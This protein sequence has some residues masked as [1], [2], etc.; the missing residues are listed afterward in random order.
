VTSRLAAPL[1]VGGGCA[2]LILLAWS[3]TNTPYDTWGALVIV[4]PLLLVGGFGLDR[5]FRGQ[6]LRVI[7]P[8]MIAGL[9]VKLVGAAVRYWVSFE[10]Y[11]GVTDAQGYHVYGDGK[12][13]S[14]WQGGVRLVD[15]IPSGT[16]TGFLEDVTAIIY[17]FTGTSR[18]GAFFVFAWIAYW[19]TA[20]FVKAAAVAV[21][22]LALRRYALLCVLAPSLV[23]WP[24]SIGKEAW[25][26]LTLGL[27]TYGI[28]N[29]FARAGGVVPLLFAVVGLGGA[30]MVR[31]HMAGIWLAGLIP[32]LLV[33][34]VRGR[35]DPDRY[36]LPGAKTAVRKGGGRLAMLV[37]AV[38]ALGGLSLA[39]GATVRYLDPGAEETGTEALST[40][41]D[42][43]RSR[44]TQE[45]GSQFTPPTA[46]GPQDW[47]YAIVRT[48]TRPLP[49]EARGTAQL[50]AAA[51]MVLLGILTIHWRR[52]V[53]NLPRM[54][55]DNRY[56]A[57]GIGVVL[58]GGL[59]YSS[60]ANLGVLTR[61][62]SLLFPFLL[63]CLCVPVVDR[64]L[65]LRS[66]GVSDSSTRLPARRGRPTR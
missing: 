54:I 56:V 35:S 4:P 3:M 61:Q 20:W 10:A 17:V 34:V 23:Y 15:M 28:A 40:V 43:A 59:A 31:P 33:G 21:P 55:L 50:L 12:A 42:E 2:Y 13:S 11:G 39:A 36:L 49:Y 14:F 58:L 52:N 9:A 46:S 30:A 66:S 48:L 32:A 60:F 19:G 29:L 26:L 22:G 53:A 51:E 65:G 1:L 57:F 18:L 5:M 41:F 47:P 38:V 63:L 27:A 6:Q 7:A 45:G 62:K 16:G 25:M 24:S 37:L 8:I 44:T 64:R